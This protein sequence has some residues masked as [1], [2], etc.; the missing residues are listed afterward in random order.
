MIQYKILEQ[1]DNYILNK[2]TNEK[3]Y[4]NNPEDMQLLVNQIN[5][6][7]NDNC[8]LSDDYESLKI[9]KN[10]IKEKLEDY[11]RIAAKYNL[12]SSSELEWLLDRIFKEKPKLKDEIKIKH[13]REYCKSIN[14]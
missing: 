12:I 14:S 6:L 7:I 2:G 10:I 5:N 8:N 9:T 13:M 11:Q 4:Y 3:F 1:K